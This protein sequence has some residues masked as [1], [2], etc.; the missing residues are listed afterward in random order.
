MTAAQ[1]RQ[2]G[3]SNNR[4]RPCTHTLAQIPPWSHFARSGRAQGWSKGADAYYESCHKP[5]GGNFMAG[6]MC[7]CRLHGTSA[8]PQGP[9]AAALR[10]DTFV[11][12]VG[13]RVQHQPDSKR[14]VLDIASGAP[15]A[16]PA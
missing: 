8:P 4:V 9:D 5:G 16:Q 12:S 15:C 3:D 1:E 13:E 14:S 2:L 7:A 6:P 10:S 11:S